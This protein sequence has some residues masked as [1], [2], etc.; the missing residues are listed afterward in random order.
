MEQYFLT[1]NTT[2]NRAV[3]NSGAE[4]D[5]SSST[6]ASPD[7]FFRSP[8]TS[9][10]MAGTTGEAGFVQTATI[11]AP[12]ASATVNFE[13]TLNSAATPRTNTT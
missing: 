6:L 9:I 5:R 12:P 1:L 2:T 4:I 10:R 3:T 8:T 11:N 7:L 13:F